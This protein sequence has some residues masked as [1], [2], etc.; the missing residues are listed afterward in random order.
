MQFSLVS[1]QRQLILCTI[2]TCYQTTCSFQVLFREHEC[3]F[4]IIS[5][6]ARELLSIKWAGIIEL[7]FTAYEEFIQITDNLRCVSSTRSLTIDRSSITIPSIWR[8]LFSSCSKVDRIYFYN[9]LDSNIFR[10]HSTICNRNDNISI[11]CFLV[12]SISHISFSFQRCSCQF[13]F[14]SAVSL[15]ITSCQD[16]CYLPS[17]YVFKSSNRSSSISIEC[18]ELFFTQCCQFLICTECIYLSTH[19]LVISWPSV[20]R[21]VAINTNSSIFSDSDIRFRFSSSVTHNE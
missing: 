13:E 19:K 17:T 11:C 4:H 16:F 7:N 18:M 5:Y 8:F 20:N 6:E 21:I 12:Y 1:V 2:N 3:I 10:I 15:I 14:S 9:M